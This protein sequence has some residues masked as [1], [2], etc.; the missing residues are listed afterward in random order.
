MLLLPVPRGP[1][2]LINIFHC[3]SQMVTLVPVYYPYFAG[4]VDLVFGTINK[5]LMV[6]L[7]LS[8]ASTL[9]QTFL[10]LSLRPFE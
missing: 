10:K 6:F 3:A 4:D 9:L 1:S 7:P 8:E 5:F 2:C